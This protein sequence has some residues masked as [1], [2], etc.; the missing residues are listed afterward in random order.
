MDRL[1]PD[2]NDLV[3]ILFF[4]TWWTWLRGPNEPYTWTDIACRCFNFVEA[5]AWFVFAALVS[6][7]WRRNRRS[8]LELWY[9]LAFVL[10][11]ISDVIETWSLT[12][13]LLWWKGV[14]LVA[15]FLLRRRVMR[16]CYPEA[17]LY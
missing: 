5:A 11:G 9:V 8:S 17:K 13:W 3:D 2:M 10:F 4:K 6:I 12:S 15:L 16:Q 1:L 7:R 14:N